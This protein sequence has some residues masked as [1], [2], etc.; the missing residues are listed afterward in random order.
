M[1]PIAADKTYIQISW[2]T[3][4][5]SPS[6]IAVCTAT[7]TLHLI[8]AIYLEYLDWLILIWL[9]SGQKT[10]VQTMLL[11]PVNRILMTSLNGYL[12]T[13]SPPHPSSPYHCM[14]IDSMSMQ[15]YGDDIL[16]LSILTS[17]IFSPS[18]ILVC[19]ATVTLH[20]IRAIYL[21]YLDWLILTWLG[22]GQK[23]EVETLLLFN[24]IFLMISI[25]MI[26]TKRFKV[27]NR[28]LCKTLDCAWLEFA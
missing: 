24:G 15:F 11:L 18:C 3:H 12:V 13:H 25:I 26:I 2:D 17:H 5:F 22:S 19:T 14:D 6:Y 27:G 28:K 4:I 1:P 16:I 8:R 9:A 7:V 21:E 20:L 23:T 10:E